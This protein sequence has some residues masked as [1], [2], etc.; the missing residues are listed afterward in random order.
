MA[1]PLL[2]QGFAK[3]SLNQAVGVAAMCLQDEPSARPFISDISAALGF[4]AMAPP[5]APIPERLVPMLSRVPTERK[6]SD[7]NQ[8]DHSSDSSEDEQEERSEKQEQEQDFISSSEYEYTDSCSEG[9][10]NEGTKNNVDN[11]ARCKS[12]KSKKLGSSSK[13][14]SRK[15]SVKITSPKKSKSKKSSRSSSRNSTQ[16][17]GK[18][19]KRQDHSDYSS[20]SDEEQ[21][22]DK[23]HASEL[24]INSRSDSCYSRSDDEN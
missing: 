12:T 21:W 5:E 8:D 3:T 24:A 2:K 14:R 10:D 13:V 18:S 11:A 19:Q 7:R 22:N 16:E 23:S 15:K 4:L 9:S 20:S 1:D 17:S 6:D